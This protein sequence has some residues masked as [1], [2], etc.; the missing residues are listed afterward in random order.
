[1]AKPIVILG[2]KG[3]LGSDLTSLCS[4]KGL[5]Y[6]QLDLPEFDITNERQLKDAL[7]DSE[8]VINCASYTDVEKAESLPQ[9]AFAV[10]ADAVGRL[11]RIAKNNSIWVCH[12]ST[13]FVFDGNK[14]EPYTEED[15]PNP[16][17]TYGKSKLAGEKLLVESGCQYCIIRI[18]WTYGLNGSN[19][20]VKLIDAAKR[21]NELKVVDDQKGSPTSTEEAAKVICRLMEKKPAG[22]YHFASAGYVTRYEMA[23][24]IFEKLGMQV[25]VSPCKTSDFA[26]AANRPLNSTFDCSKI[27][28]LLAEPIENWQKPLMR[29]L[30]KL[31]EKGMI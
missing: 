15:K 21:K 13:D 19:F 30:V 18:E 7:K 4:Q 17:N 16:I 11:G 14:K 1:M 26:S 23:K 12:I 24:F 9:K 3:M 31:T 5:N 20:I 22:I 6:R 29:F 2:G 10:N 8:V 28:P 25:S 27:G